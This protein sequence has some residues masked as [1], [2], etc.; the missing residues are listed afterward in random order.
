M[1]LPVVG[2]CTSLEEAYTRALY[3]YD[4]MT[5]SIGGEHRRLQRLF[6]RYMYPLQSMF[7]T[8]YLLTPHELDTPVNE[9]TFALSGLHVV[10]DH[11]VRFYEHPT[12]EALDTYDVDLEVQELKLIYGY[13]AGRVFPLEPIDDK[14]QNGIVLGIYAVGI[15]FDSITDPSREPR[16]TYVPLEGLEVLN[17]TFKF[18]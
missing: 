12:D 3:T 9:M 11:V 6:E 5:L 1:R 18:E 4:K 10:A 15:D 2:P 17:R 16:L 8:E 14:D 7:Q 13:M